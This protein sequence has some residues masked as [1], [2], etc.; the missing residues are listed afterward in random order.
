MFFFK[1][2]FCENYL[3]HIEQA[4][5]FSPVGIVYVFSTAPFVSIP[6]HFLSTHVAFH[7]Y[8]LIHDFSNRPFVKM[9]CHILNRH[10]A[11]HQCGLIYAFLN[12]P[13]VKMSFH[14]LNRH[15]AFHQDGLIHVFSN[16]L[17]W[18]LLVTNWTGAFHPC[19]SVSVFSSAP[20][21]RMPCNQCV[22]CALKFAFNENALSHFEQGCG[23]SPVWISSCVFKFSFRLEP[24]L[25]KDVTWHN[26]VPKDRSK[27]SRLDSLLAKIF[28]LYDMWTVFHINQHFGRLWLDTTWFQNTN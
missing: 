25:W 16:Y 22:L 12:R 10:V 24:T 26:M 7:Q 3:S 28:Y 23:F 1:F 18:K 13:F 9:S 5:G 19:E 27:C 8:G 14:V 17:L 2:S 21:V 15:L 6:C 4:R 11:F 20:F